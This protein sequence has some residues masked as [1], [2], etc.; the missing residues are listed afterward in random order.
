MRTLH[1]V[2]ILCFRRRWK[3]WHIL[4]RFLHFWN[5][6]CISQILYEIF[7][8]LS[9][10]WLL[11]LKKKFKGDIIFTLLLSEVFLRIFWLCVY[12]SLFWIVIQKISKSVYV[13]CV[14]RLIPCLYFPKKSDDHNECKT[15]CVKIYC[16]LYCWIRYFS[17]ANNF[18]LQR[19]K[20]QCIPKSFKTN[21]RTMTCLHSPFN[22]STYQSCNWL[23]HNNTRNILGLKKSYFTTF[24][25]IIS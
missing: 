20:I 8:L 12:N 17:K 25:T 11:F 14:N 23:V 2:R 10:I 16:V 15:V 19:F 24:N 3:T 22:D 6:F 9:P 7:M 1:I 13:W 18:K 4:S 5:F 21:N